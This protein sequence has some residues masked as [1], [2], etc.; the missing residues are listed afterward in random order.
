MSLPLSDVHYHFWE[1]FKGESGTLSRTA[2][3]L[4]TLG[5][6]SVST[7]AE[8]RILISQFFVYDN[9]LESRELQCT[10]MEFRRLE[11]ECVL[12]SSRN[13]THVEIQTG[14]S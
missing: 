9:F 5:T 3:L 7:R 8:D 6:I 4:H 10:C 2:N 12:V 13:Y 1:I 11:G 14:N